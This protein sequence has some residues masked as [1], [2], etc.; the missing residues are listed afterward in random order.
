MVSRECVATRVES[1]GGSHAAHAHGSPERV[2]RIR[3][4]DRC[5]I[6]GACTDRKT[7]T[8]RVRRHGC[9]SRWKV[10]IAPARQSLEACLI[11]MSR[12]VSSKAGSQR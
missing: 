9:V 12:Q 6:I 3:L 2:S 10:H 1:G 7:N 4:S 8:N 5:V 11:A